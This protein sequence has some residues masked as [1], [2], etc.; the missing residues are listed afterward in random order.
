MK[1]LKLL[2]LAP[3]FLWG[4]TQ[5]SDKKEEITPI[6][7]NEVSLTDGFWKNRMKTELEVTVPFSVQQSGPAVER[8]R[9]AAAYLAGDTTQVPIPHRF[10]SSD[11]PRN[12]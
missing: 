4:C 10:I 11:M 3:M 1:T 7:F 6:P 5:T 12:G 2:A 8:F 9:Q